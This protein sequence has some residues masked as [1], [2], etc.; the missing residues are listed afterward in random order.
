MNTCKKTQ[1]IYQNIANIV[2]TYGKFTH[3]SNL[4]LFLLDINFN[5]IKIHFYNA[6]Y[7]Q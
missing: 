6:D 1:Q 4:D 5:Q 7:H 2:I 3:Y